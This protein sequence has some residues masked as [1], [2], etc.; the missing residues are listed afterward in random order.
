MLHALSRMREKRI[1]EKGGRE[2]NF[3][4]NWETD[5]G[6][7]LFTPA[8]NPRNNLREK[9]RDRDPAM[10]KSKFLEHL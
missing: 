2:E 7:V 10:C 4:Q 3:S 1:I 9:L 5:N 8:L 6:W